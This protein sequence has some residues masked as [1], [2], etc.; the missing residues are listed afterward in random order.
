MNKVC[1]IGK[2]TKYLPVSNGIYYA[3]VLQKGQE[4]ISNILVIILLLLLQSQIKQ[5]KKK[6]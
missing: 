1:I 2:G 5:L 4:Y 3:R 6:L